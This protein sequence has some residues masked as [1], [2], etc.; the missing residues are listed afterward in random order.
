MRGEEEKRAKRISYVNDIR[1][2]NLIKV[3][4]HRV[5]YPIP[6]NRIKERQ[7]YMDHGQRFSILSIHLYLT[8]HEL[9]LNRLNPNIKKRIFD[10]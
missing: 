7:Q 4:I 5:I 3:I 10:L 1:F 2:G 8:L 9:S 6:N